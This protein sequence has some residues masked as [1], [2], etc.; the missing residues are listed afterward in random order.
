MCFFR[1]SVFFLL[2]L[3][4]KSIVLFGEVIE[5]VFIPN[6]RSA[7]L[8]GI[9]TGLGDDFYTIFTNPASFVGIE[10]QFSAGELSL[11]VYGPIFEIIDL[12]RNALDSGNNLDISGITGAA[13]FTAGFDMAGPVSLGWVGRG[14][15][16][17]IFN[18]TKA[19]ASMTGTTVRPLLLE[20]ILLV[21]GYSFR[22]ID[23]KNHIL[24]AGFLGKGFYRG[25]LEFKTS[26]FD[27]MSMFD[28]PMNNEF[29]TYL[30]LGVDLGLRYTFADNLTFALVCYDVYSPTLVTVY[31]SL[32]DF[33]DKKYPSSSGNYAT[34][35]RCLNAGIKYRIRSEF[36]D[37]YISNLIILADYRDML[38]LFA[39]IPR[40][41]ILNIGL[42]V[43][44]L[45]LNVLSL[46]AGITDALPAAGFG[47]DFG[48]TR[49]DCAIHG[50]ELGLDPGVQPVYAFDIALLFRY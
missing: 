31:D 27:A 42:G 39:P 26:V 12:A 30:G 5:P 32:N 37:R 22:F 15:G 14:L 17:G 1:F 33:I 8:G 44:L 23:K 3:L 25:S 47:I 43:E 24:D 41:P 21:G 45:A 49:F 18:R 6:A 9:H 10:D 7:A 16:L 38:D 46:R 20:D 19:K 50:K 2:C 4:P 36:L 13:G 29:K 28:D 11:S 48:I 40:N 34:V 35:Y